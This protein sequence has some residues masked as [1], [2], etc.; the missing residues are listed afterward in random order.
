MVRRPLSVRAAALDFV[1]ARTIYNAV[2]YQVAWLAI[3]IGA[4]QGYGWAGALIAL[5]VAAIHVASQRSRA[6]ELKLIAC[7]VAVGVAHETL[8]MQLGFVD[9]TPSGWNFALAPYWMVALWVAFATTFRHSL[10]WV[11]RRPWIAIAAGAVGGPLAYLAGARLGALNLADFAVPALAVTFALAMA[12]LAAACRHVSREPA[13][14]GQAAPF[15][16]VAPYSGIRRGWALLLSPSRPALSRACLSSRSR[17]TAGPSGTL[18]RC[19]PGRVPGRPAAPHSGEVLSTSDRTTRARSWARGCLS[20]RLAHPIT[21]RMQ[22]NAT[23]SGSEFEIIA[24]EPHESVPLRAQLCVLEP[25]RFRS[26][27]ALRNPQP[28]NTGCRIRASGRSC[29][30]PKP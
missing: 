21:S 11:M 19:A 7:A 13:A 9:F 25:G 1:V 15:R 16:G 4:A 17:P 28:V 22:V 10:H 14:T 29:S 27:Y 8:L 20:D 18:A 3:I 2:A 26:A 6:A 12:V 23:R 24:A 30:R 5:A